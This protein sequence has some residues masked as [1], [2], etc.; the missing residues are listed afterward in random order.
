MKFID[1]IETATHI[2]I[3]T[4]YCRDGDLK[5]M[6]NLKKLSE[7]EGSDFNLNYYI[8]FIALVHVTNGFKEL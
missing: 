3:I 2:Y 7:Q 4:E 5:E 1:L 8:A 6:L